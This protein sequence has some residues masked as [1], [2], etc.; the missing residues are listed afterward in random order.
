MPTLVAQSGNLV[1]PLAAIIERLQGKLTEA[2]IQ[3]VLTAVL[4][5][6]PTQVNPG[7]LITA[8]QMNRVLFELAD[9]R[10]RL[11][12]LE[13]GKPSTAKRVQISAPEPTD[14]YRIGEPL[15]I[16]GEGLLSDSLIMIGNTAIAGAFGSPDDTS[17]TIKTIPALDISGGLPSGGKTVTLSVSN[18]LGGDTTQFILKPFVQTTP[19]GS[20]IIAP[21][22][23]PSAST[24]YQA[25]GNY[26][27]KFRVTA[28]TKPDI[29]FLVSAQTGQSTWTAQPSQSVLFVPAAQSA[30][31][32]TIAEFSV[33]V[34]ISGTAQSG[35]TGNL[36]VTLTAEGA[37]AFQWRSTPDIVITVGNAP[38]QVAPLNIALSLSTAG[39]A[40]IRTNSDGS[41][42]ALIGPQGDTGGTGVLRFAIT[43]VDGSALPAG[44]YQVDLT[45]W[46]NLPTGW[47]AAVDGS[48][49]GSINL[50]G[51][52]QTVP[53]SVTVSATAQ[54]TTLLTVALS[55][56]GDSSLLGEGSFAMERRA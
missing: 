34:A 52:G 41:R 39:Q 25:N 17:L 3:A 1:V 54:R 7:E 46:K 28:D 4:G 36:F 15:I 27:F 45:K 31:S 6:L 29:R 21:A 37:A 19:I 22:G 50:S 43:R 42:T 2:E 13:A 44:D 9:H 26:T 11:A 20:L 10:L 35:D 55:R 53:I 49:D 8:Q 5:G 48:T 12:R 24:I 18:E 33:T 38:D 30:G 47:T 32:P 23:A 14:I 40:A 56:V 16:R 51:S